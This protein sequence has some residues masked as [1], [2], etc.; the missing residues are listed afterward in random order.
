MFS[1]IRYKLTLFFTGILIVFLISF[2]IVS[3]FLLSSMI[4]NG[5]EKD[6]QLLADIQAKDYAALLLGG[7]ESTNDSSGY[8][9]G[10][11]K[12]EEGSGGSHGDDDSHVGDSYE[13]E[14]HSEM[15]V[16]GGSVLL[17]FYYALDKTGRLIATDQPYSL[18]DEQVVKELIAWTPPSPS[19]IKYMDYKRS[20][21]ETVHL[22]FAGR[23]IYSDGQYAGS[24]YTGADISQQSAILSQMM[25]ILSMISGAFLLFAAGVGYFMSGRAM[26]PIIRSFHRQQQFVADASHELRTPLSVIHSSLEVIESEEASRLQPFSRQVLH[27]LLDEVKGMS[28][29]VS[30]LLILARADS[31]EVPLHMEAFL[32]KEELEKLIRR[33]QPLAEKKA[34]HLILEPCAEDIKLRADRERIRQ[35]MGILLDNAIQYT[36]EQGSIRIAVSVG[37]GKLEIAVADSGMGIPPEKLGSIFERFVR[38]DASRSRSGGNAGLG[39]SIAMWIATT[40]G[41]TIRVASR[42]GLGSTFTVVLP[43]SA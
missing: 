4:T 35:L 12:R 27:D 29:L 10:R 37:K 16:E 2:N 32:L 30:Q 15:E 17:P 18:S 36:P 13:D 20:S 31:G 24:I 3:Y 26:A 34:L 1:K 19:Q 25:W 6:I 14:E 8:R 22:M 7:R 40:H 42:E 28:S 11:D 43:Q 5:R 41:G 9:T 21:K 23:P 33:F 39:L 38:V